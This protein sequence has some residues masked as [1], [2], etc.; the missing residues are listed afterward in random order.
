MKPVYL[1]LSLASLIASVTAAPGSPELTEREPV[2]PKPKP[3]YADYKTYYRDGCGLFASKCGSGWAGKCEAFCHQQ[4]G[5]F[6]HMKKTDCS[7]F[8]KRCC[9]TQLW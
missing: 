6:S 9:C 5:V 7:L 2:K 4:H 8:S 3:K 1:L